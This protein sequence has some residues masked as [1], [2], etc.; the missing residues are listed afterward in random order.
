MN[1]IRAL[2]IVSMLIALSHGALFAA[3]DT[4]P[5]TREVH[6][7]LHDRSELDW[8]YISIDG[9]NRG[10]ARKGQALVLRLRV[11]S[12]FSILASRLVDG[13]MYMRER[14]QFIERGVGRQWVVLSP[15]LQN[16]DRVEPRGYVHITLSEDAEISW[17]NITINNVSYGM[18]RRGET[19]RFWL[20]AD[21]E[22]RIRLERKSNEQNYTIEKTVMLKEGQTQ[23]LSLSP[24][25]SR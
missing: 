25:Q 23:A 4:D 15:E 21:M 9:E 24:R 1:N 8:V 19:R 20:K 12:S 18:L 13:K 11:G 10:V 6:I 2:L 3:P 22:H 7:T 17:G 5:D 14:I 16:S